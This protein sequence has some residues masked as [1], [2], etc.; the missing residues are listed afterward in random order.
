MIFEKSCTFTG[1]APS[2]VRWAF[3]EVSTVFVTAFYTENIIKAAE[4]ICQGFSLLFLLCI[5]HKFIPGSI[6]KFMEQFIRFASYR[7]LIYFR[8]P[9]AES[10]G[11]GNDQFVGIHCLCYRNFFCSGWY[12]Q[13]FCGL[14][15]M[16]NGN[17][18]KNLVIKGMIYNAFQSI[19]KETLE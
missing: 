12:S 18:R 13:F 19:R 11:T 9:I 16:L 6:L 1:L 17:S 3:P 7:N 8:N 2:P 4:E 5:N 14:N 15:Q 10:S